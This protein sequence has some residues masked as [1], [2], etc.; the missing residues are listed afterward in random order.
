VAKVIPPAEVKTTPQPSSSSN[1]NALDDLDSPPTLN[2]DLGNF[3]IFNAL[4]EP[5]PVA[6]SNTKPTSTAASSSINKTLVINTTNNTDSLNFVFDSPKTTNTQP[7]TILDKDSFPLKDITNKD[8]ITKVDPD[9]LD[10]LISPPPQ[11][12]IKKP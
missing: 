7:R 5:V 11:M 4:T 9:V 8:T 1:A 6:T 10:F 2:F 3:T 12:N